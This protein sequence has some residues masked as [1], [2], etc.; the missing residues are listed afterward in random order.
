MYFQQINLFY[1]VNQNPLNKK[2]E[3]ELIKEIQTKK[4][5]KEKENKENKENKVRRRRILLN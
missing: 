2:K 3:K 5:K 1:F 4:R